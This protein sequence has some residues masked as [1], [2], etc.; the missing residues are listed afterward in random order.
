MPLEFFQQQTQLPTEKLKRQ[1]REICSSKLKWR[2]VGLMKW[3]KIDVIGGR[4]K[5]VR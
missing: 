1:K 3:G 2:N 5:S 4:V